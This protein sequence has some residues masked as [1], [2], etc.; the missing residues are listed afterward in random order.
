MMATEPSIRVV[1]EPRFFY[2][3]AWWTARAI[4]RVA[5]RAGSE[6][7]YA[8]AIRVAML[9]VRIRCPA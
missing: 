8:L 9:G 7:L 6:H 5:A 3:L 2:P 1:V 4:S